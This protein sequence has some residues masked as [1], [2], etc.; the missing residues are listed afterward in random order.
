[1]CYNTVTMQ[2]IPQDEY[3]TQED[4]LVRLGYNKNARSMFSR[5]QLKKLIPFK[6]GKLI[7]YRKSENMWVFEE[8]K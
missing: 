1:M 5:P 7:R 3:Y 8:K 6:I 2:T 4:I